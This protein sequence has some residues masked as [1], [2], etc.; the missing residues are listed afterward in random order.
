LIAGHRAVESY[1]DVSHRADSFICRISKP[2]R[3]GEVLPKFFVRGWRT[4]SGCTRAIEEGTMS[5][6]N[7]LERPMIS[8]N[9]HMVKLLK[10]RV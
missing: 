10:E 8:W 9:R 4:V 1:M 2:P 3:A 7:G 5:P 6:L